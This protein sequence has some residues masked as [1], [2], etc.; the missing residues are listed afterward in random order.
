MLMLYWHNNLQFPSSQFKWTM[1]RKLISNFWKV[2]EKSVS[3]SSLYFMFMFN[4]SFSA[5]VSLDNANTSFLFVS[6]LTVICLTHE[7]EDISTKIFENQSAGVQLT[8][9]RIS[10]CSSPLLAQTNSDEKSLIRNN[11]LLNNNFAHIL[12]QNPF[13]LVETLKV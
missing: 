6:H 9:S 11:F 4:F 8:K 7:K 3:P 10:N 1:V 2:T 5:A 12:R 13:N